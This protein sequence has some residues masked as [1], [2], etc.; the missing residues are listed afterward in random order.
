MRV[1]FFQVGSSKILNRTHN[2]R[3]IIFETTLELYY[4]PIMLY[5]IVCMVLTCWTFYLYL[6]PSGTFDLLLNQ[7]LSRDSP[8]ILQRTFTVL[9]SECLVILRISMFR[10][11]LDSRRVHLIVQMTLLYKNKPL[12]NKIKKWPIRIKLCLNASKWTY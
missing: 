4:V 10:S 3:K 12:N 8:L 5:C 9:S 7:V 2:F 1:N 11:V 6:S